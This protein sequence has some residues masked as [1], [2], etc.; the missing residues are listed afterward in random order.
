MRT[1]GTGEQEA[2]RRKRNMQIF[3]VLLLVLLGLSTLGYAFF[4]NPNVGSSNQATG[5]N[6][7]VQQISDGQ[8]A[9]Q[10]GQ[11]PQIVL[12]TSPAEARNVPVETKPTLADFAGK[13]VYI[14]AP[15]SILNEIGTALSPYAS[16]I[17]PACYGSCTKDLPE[18]DCNDTMIVVKESETGRI[19][20][21]DGCFFIEGNKTTA[22]AFIYSVFNMLGQ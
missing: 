7:T 1:I 15:D 22:D 14:D 17:Q 3:S 9:F 21:Q 12:T 5:G 2:D 16:R 19:Y 8:W 11:Q 4:S 6:G 20:G 10:V 13:T 18:H